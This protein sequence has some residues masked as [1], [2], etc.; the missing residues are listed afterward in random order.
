MLPNGYIYQQD[1]APA[2]TSNVTKAWFEEKGIEVLPWPAKL[3]D[4]N[5]I[6]NLW[7]IVARAVY[8]NGQRQFDRV[9]DLKRAMDS[10]WNA[11]DTTT[12][13]KLT[14]SMTK[15]CMDVLERKGGHIEY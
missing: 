12:L 1:N 14:T 11:I 9:E 3:P 5:P 8:Q 10:S 4:L 7:G 6:K 13:S 15:R 2:H